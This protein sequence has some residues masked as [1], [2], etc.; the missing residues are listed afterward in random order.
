MSIENMT[1]IAPAGRTAVLERP[2]AQSG[3]SGLSEAD[4]ARLAA[5]KQ[6][7]SQAVGPGVPVGGGGTPPE[8]PRAPEPTFG[9]EWEARPE[10]G[11]AVAR[12][13]IRLETTLSY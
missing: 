5:I 4:R 11:R 8:G 1:E 7:V 10:R 12:E 9:P 6:A 3:G 2:T 13:I